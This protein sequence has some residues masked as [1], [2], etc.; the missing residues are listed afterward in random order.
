MNVK[1]KLELVMEEP[2]QFSVTIDIGNLASAYNS[3]VILQ[4]QIALLKSIYDAEQ[5]AI[6]SNKDA[7][8]ATDTQSEDSNESK[9][10]SSMCCSD[11]CCDS[12]L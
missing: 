1:G 11:E 8:N 2:V 12:E 4:H 10:C 5:K 6:E 7:S 9:C 3:S